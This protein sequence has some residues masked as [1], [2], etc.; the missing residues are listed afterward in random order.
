M[1]TALSRKFSLKKTCNKAASNGLPFN[2][3]E[4]CVM[5]VL[6]CAAQFESCARRLFLAHTVLPS[7]GH[8]EETRDELS[9]SS[10]RITERRPRH[11][12]EHILHLRQVVTITLAYIQEGIWAF[13][14]IPLQC[15]ILCPNG[16]DKVPTKLN[17]FITSSR[18]SHCS[19]SHGRCRGTAKCDLNAIIRTAYDMYQNHNQVSLTRHQYWKSGGRGRRYPRGH[20]VALLILS[21]ETSVRIQCTLLMM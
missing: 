19:F 16:T 17:L 18:R 9:T 15:Q 12:N 10:E 14:E 4:H 21:R 3:C 5:I 6:L 8:F 7:T 13:V 20:V 11:R 2:A 1:S